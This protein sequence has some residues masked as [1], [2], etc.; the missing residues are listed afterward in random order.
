[1]LDADRSFRR[2][3]RRDGYLALEDMGLIGDGTTSAL[4]GLDGSA[5]WLCPPRFD[6]QPALVAVDDHRVFELEH[7]LGHP[8]AHRSRRELSG[9][10]ALR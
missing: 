5:A 3:R 4:V 8:I 2:V 6:S 7:M 1:V 9:R 10:G